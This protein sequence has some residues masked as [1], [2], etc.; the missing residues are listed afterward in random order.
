MFDSLTYK[1]VIIALI[2]VVSA[3]IA[4]VSLHRTSRLQRQ[5]MHLNAKQEELVDRQLEMLRKQVDM[6][7][8][9]VETS[10]TSRPQIEKA[11]V[12]VDIVEKGSDYRFVITNWGRG[13]AHDIGF[14]LQLMEG[15]SS[16]FVSGDYD[17]K[18]PIRQLAP[19]SRCSLFAAL[20]FDTGTSFDA[21]WTWTNPDGSR[22]ERSSL[23]TT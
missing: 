19:G 3:V 5:Q 13:T 15:R 4:F 21:T 1:D 2:A 11:D 20:T 7:P 16:P 23:L 14:D 6:E 22:E 10:L 18:I 17:E 9:E 8:K 12:R